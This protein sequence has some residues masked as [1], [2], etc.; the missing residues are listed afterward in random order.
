[1]IRLGRKPFFFYLFLLLAFSGSG[2]NI[3]N[4]GNSKKFARYLF[5]TQQYNLA[6]IEYERILNISSPDAEVS[7]QLLK[8]FRLG[9]I[10]NNSFQRIDNLEL[11]RFFSNDTVSREFLNL[12]LTCNCCY[13]YG[14]FQKAL[15]A[16]NDEEQAFYRLGYFFFEEE[17]D[18]LYNFNTSNSVLL[19]ASYPSVFQSIEKMD[20]F[21][22]KS[23]GLAMAMSAILPGSGKAYSGFWGDAVM[24]L[25][26]VSSNAWLSYRGFEKRGVKSASGWIFGG[27]TLGFYF[28]NI[29]GSSRAAKTYNRIEYEKLYNEA[30]SNIYNHF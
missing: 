28:G 10:C 15:T 21:R 17:L 3:F 13:E 30:K 7:S 9:N 5:N 26:F 1:M 2:Q 16:L 22:K 18:S 14:R 12:A 25:L 8:S 27:A 23:L 6:A 4:A 24:S 11:Y 29:W 19:S 20:N